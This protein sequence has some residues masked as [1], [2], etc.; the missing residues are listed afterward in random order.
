MDTWYNPQILTD[1]A[2]YTEVELLWHIYQLHLAAFTLVFALVLVFL[3]YKAV[4]WLVPNF[5]YKGKE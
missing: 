5:W 3:S 1:F 2:P 4:I